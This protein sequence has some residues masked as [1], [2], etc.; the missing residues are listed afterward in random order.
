MFV[1]GSLRLRTG[2]GANPDVR[3]T[4]E[5]RTYANVQSLAARV[6]AQDGSE[7]GC[8]GGGMRK[9]KARRPP[10]TLA[11]AERAFASEDRERRQP[12]GW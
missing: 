12:P 9:G 7:A 10:G 3:T 8:L 4:I 1:S 6:I 11:D 5:R 2:S